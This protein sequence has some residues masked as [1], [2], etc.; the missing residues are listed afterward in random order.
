MEVNGVKC[1][2]LVDSGASVSLCSKEI[3]GPENKVDMSKIPKVKGVS[4]NYL[5]VL[6]NTD[7]SCKIGDFSYD[8]KNITV[9][10][11]MADC[12]F[13]MGR[14]ILEPHNC[15]I[16][17]RDLTL[18]IDEHKFPLIKAYNGKHL[19]RPVAIHSNTTYNIPAHSSSI[20]TCH[21]RSGQKGKNQKIYL[22]TSGA[23]ESCP[24][25]QESI[26]VPNCLVNTNRGKTRIIIYNMTEH[27]I[28]LYK[29]KK[30]GTLETFHSSELSALNAVVG[31]HATTPSLLA[32]PCHDSTASV[33]LNSINHIK[34]KD[35]ISEITDKITKLCEE[36]ELHNSIT[37]TKN[38]STDKKSY[39][40]KASTREENIGTTDPPKVTFA[41]HDTIIPTRQEIIHDNNGM[42]D[43]HEM[44]HSQDIHEMHK[45][46]KYAPQCNN[47]VDQTSASKLNANS[48]VQPNHIR[49]SKNISKLHEIL[50]IDKLTNL[51]EAEKMQVKELITEFR[52]IF[53]EGEDDMGTTDLAEH[54]IILKDKTPIR[55]KY[56]NVPLALKAKAENEVKRL[57]DLRIIE[58]S[59]SSFHSPSFCT[60]KKDGSIRILT[61]F[62]QLNKKIQRTSAPVPGLQDLVALWKGCNL[63]STLDFQ[64]GFFQ[65]P[66]TKRSRK[67]TA[68]SLPG[69]A[70]FQYLKSPMGL[71]SSPGFFQSFIEKLLLGIKQ[72]KCVAFLDDILA[73]NQNYQQHLSGL[74]EVFERIRDS[75]ML[76]KAEKCKIFCEQITYL[77]H[78]LSINGIATC[79]KKVEAIE[80]MMPP[81]NVK[82][83]KSFLGL[84]GFYRR[85]IHNYAQICEPLS[86]MTRNNA[87]FNWTPE[88]ESAWKLIKSKLA[89][90][91]ILTHPD[92]EKEY[93]LI[94]DASSYA[95][96]SILCQ[97]GDDGQLH[98]ISYGSS[99]LSEAQR[100]WSTVQK[101]LYSLVHFSEKF[102]S[103][104]INT[105]F[106]AI[107]DNKALLHLDTFKNQKN[108]RLWRW[109]ESLQKFEFT[110][111][112]SPS[113]QNPS[114]ALSRLPMI[115][116]ELIDTL[117]P[118]AEIDRPN[119]QPP[120]MISSLVEQNFEL[121]VS[122]N[123]E[124]TGVSKS[125][126]LPVVEYENNKIGNAQ[127]SDDTIKTVKSWIL[128]GSKPPS[129]SGLTTDLKT[130]Y[131]SFD[132]LKIDQSILVRSWE[133][134]TPENPVWLA[135]IPGSIQEEIIGLCHD[136]PESGHL[137]AQKT[138]QRIRTAFYFPKMDLKSKLHVA[139]CHVCLKKR[140]QHKN[141][142]APITP[143]SGTS[144]G[145]LVFMD[146][147][148]ALPVANGFK[149]I[150][151]IIDSFTKW[152]ECIP[153]RSTKAEYIARALLNTWVSRQGVMDHLHSDRGSNVDGAQILKALYKMLGIHKT[154]NIAYRPQTDGMA[155]RMVGTLKG[156]L[157][158]YCQEN[159]NNWINC[160]EQ[161]IFA[162]RTSVHSS[163]GF[164]PFFLD[165][166][167]LPRLPMHILMGVKPKTIMG[168]HYSDYTYN[169][170][171]KLQNA[172][173]VANDAI[174][175]KQI[176]SKRHH[177]IDINVQ[178]FIE[179]E[180]VYIW[181]PAPKGCEGRKFYD[182]WRGPFEI[183]KKL[184]THS[185][186]I[187]LTEDKFD[188]VHMEL[189]KAAAPPANN[190][191]DK[192][193]ITE[194]NDNTNPLKS[195]DD[196]DSESDLIG[197]PD[198]PQRRYPLRNRTQRVPYQH[199][200]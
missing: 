162:Y 22:T 21:L 35:E 136:P 158:K 97:K 161:V 112:Y 91:P 36:H 124:N 153:L 99:I 117:P 10:E 54:D 65:T 85:F 184:T 51:S 40:S 183:V 120:N 8:L 75:K 106:H 84:S 67:Y 108:D 175:T 160:L 55:G 185:Y 104:L 101:E 90:N 181:K 52:D 126:C 64:K 62:R 147:M 150:L 157:W 92:L 88:A 31:R 43:T 105:K 182:H 58:P 77:G 102:E 86:R 45:F 164:S 30:V 48:T 79:P 109:F 41:T 15:I 7:I 57:M 199:T 26:I 83:V 134:N 125:P 87:S 115:N 188:V 118:C 70:F 59:S 93:H 142:K 18:Q 131:S 200:P 130:Y 129:T 127:D 17:F 74:R 100:K 19:K 140:R 44:H 173:A 144:P 47:M 139:A 116:D 121:S 89:S 56:Y 190:L 177:D 187:K 137:G 141:L 151:I 155:E 189:M 94:F 60:I 159:P 82:G 113:K 107:T 61:D 143:F 98:P 23:L 27:P 114:D 24:K 4:G 38:I 195:R 53:A 28:C 37:Y 135:C 179:G 6:G 68:T 171:H 14:D 71:S 186:Q 152:A 198:Q 3:L 49:W 81:K 119:I 148:E 133:Q 169:L 170:Y 80:K 66:L 32:P 1:Y 197:L 111:S 73:G 178:N 138:L 9:V 76:L 5:N 180:W 146:I 163:T 165:K 168:K 2:G 123:D 96:G 25:N 50:G 193:V 11:E 176:S 34:I 16:N 20:I 72:S 103:Y 167:R 46:D 128:N 192:N 145:E 196:S 132:R 174:R 122:D 172:Y 194:T 69:I 110:I 12:V 149:S 63:Y 39:V 154:A 78:I 13:I 95:V 191:A 33:Q 166:G 29:N 156:M 42:H